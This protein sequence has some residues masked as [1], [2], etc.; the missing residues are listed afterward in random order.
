MVEIESANL[1]DSGDVDDANGV[2]V[3][4]M[5]G[6][7]GLRVPDS[8][9]AACGDPP[10]TAARSQNWSRTS[11]HPHHSVTRNASQHINTLMKSLL[12][13]SAQRRE[14]SSGKGWKGGQV[15]TCRRPTFLPAQKKRK[16]RSVGQPGL[17]EDSNG[18]LRSTRMVAILAWVECK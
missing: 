4:G 9:G 11:T 10:P 1:G 15:V 6:F 16:R 13:T 14:M 8:A 2:A 7:T 5:G 17:V 18:L 12:I 3:E